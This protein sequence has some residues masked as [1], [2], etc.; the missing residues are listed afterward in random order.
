VRLRAALVAVCALL[1]GCAGGGESADEVLSETAANLGKIRSG[2]LHVDL[3]VEPR[4]PTGTDAFGFAL[5][6]PFSLGGSTPLPVADIEYT[7]TVGDDSA[8]VTV[9]STGTKAFIRTQGQTYELPAEQAAQLQGAA[10]QL[11]AGA[12]L[13]E[14][15]IDEWI[16]DADVDDGGDVGGADTDHVTA[17]LNVVAAVR[18]LVALAR[19]LGQNV[20]ELSDQDVDR[21]EDSVRS[22]RFEVYTGKD[23]RLLRRLELEVDFGL[24]VP[25]E[26][27]GAFGSLVGARLL[28]ELGVDD[29]NR[30]VRVEEP[31]NAL[32]S[33]ELPGG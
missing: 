3:R 9:I 11:R 8:T 28:F 32:P 18:D 29:P 24:D 14:F 26:L 19:Q 31:E 10:G 5:D 21:L 20:P 25:R 22:S 2:T 33:S 1:A 15:A 6:G 30:E 16:E 4:G 17:E 13:G 27:R 12:G 23:D 7:Q